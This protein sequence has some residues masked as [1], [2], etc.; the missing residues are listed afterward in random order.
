MCGLMHLLALAWARLA[1]SRD[2]GG[3][4]FG[5]GCGG[6]RLASIA[7]RGKLSVG[8]DFPGA[9]GEVW[10]HRRGERRLVVVCADASRSKGSPVLAQ[11][12]KVR[13]L[14]LWCAVPA[15][16][17]VGAIDGSR[18]RLAQSVLDETVVIGFLDPFVDN[19]AGPCVDHLVAEDGCLVV[20]CASSADVATGFGEENWDVVLGGVLLQEDVARGLESGVA[21]PGKGQ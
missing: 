10:A 16:S 19:G 8:F 12:L 18:G 9:S 15:E 3:R 21:A 11:V 4:D 13:I 7:D 2:D 17:C 6:Y 5:L 20:E 1:T 14:G